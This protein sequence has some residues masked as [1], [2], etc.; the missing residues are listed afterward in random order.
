MIGTVLS[1]LHILTDLILKIIVKSRY[2]YYLHYRR[3][4][5]Q[6]YEASKSWSQ[7]SNPGTLAL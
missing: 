4:H 2:H 5:A 6:G 1:T 7:D 3:K